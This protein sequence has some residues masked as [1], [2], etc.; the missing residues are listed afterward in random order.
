MNIL[1]LGAGMMGRA[2]AFDLHNYSNFD[3]S[4]KITLHQKRI[5]SPFFLV[6]DIIIPIL[7]KLVNYFFKVKKIT[8]F[9]LELF[10]YSVLSVWL[11]YIIRNE[12]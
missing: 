6:M 8:D 9:I 11:L 3:E 4:K 7:V 10:S 2:I 5:F 12:H 1:V